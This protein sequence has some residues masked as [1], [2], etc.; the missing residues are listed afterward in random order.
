MDMYLLGAERFMEYLN[1]HLSSLKITLNDYKSD[2]P[3]Y[4]V[5]YSL[6]GTSPTN[7]EA[8]GNYIIHEDS[9]MMQRE[10]I[11]LGLLPDHIPDDK[12]T[13]RKSKNPVFDSLGKLEYRLLNRSIKKVFPS[14]ICLFHAEY[15]KELPQLNIESA[16]DS[17]KNSH[18]DEIKN[19]LTKIF[20][21]KLVQYLG[22]DKDFSEEELGR[23][24]KKLTESCFGEKTPESNAIGTLLIRTSVVK[25]T[26][27]TI[28]NSKDV[29][30]VTIFHIFLKDILFGKQNDLVRFI[31]DSLKPFKNSCMHQYL[32][33]HLSKELEC[34]STLSITN[35]ERIPFP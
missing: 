11:F 10:K 7:Q 21:F 4:Q 19:E 13:F 34:I 27:K 5:I 25:E 23:M 8:H 20:R 32:V 30:D 28:M 14:N 9:S 1:G 16:W 31:D 24:S 3:L 18:I 2:G 29:E 12:P 33:D 17:Y 22:L 26:E 15:F 35:C 6:E